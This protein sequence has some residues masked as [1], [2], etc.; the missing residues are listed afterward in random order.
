MPVEVKICGITNLDDAEAAVEYGADYLGFILYPG[1]PRAVDAATMRSIVG[2]LGPSVRPV[3]VFVNE[4]REH[5]ER[6]IHE[7]DVAAVQ[8]HG[9]ETAG[10]FTDMPVPIWRVVRLKDGAWDPSPEQWPASRYLV[11]ATVPGRYGGTGVR[12]D[13]DA[14]GKLA[15]L[16]PVMLAGGLTPENVAEAVRTVRPAGV[17][18][19]SGVE[20]A[21]GRKDHRKLSE[22]IRRAKRVADDNP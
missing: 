16:H 4:P 8:L 1:S 2:D 19:V 5:V 9:R 18:V 20:S 15:A 17:D 14:A 21:P 13:W 6:V 22:F 3:A 11:D 12:A 7:C 10:D